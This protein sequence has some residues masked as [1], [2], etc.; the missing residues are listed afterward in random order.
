MTTSVSSAIRTFARI[1]FRGGIALIGGMLADT[2]L[3]P[4]LDDKINDFS[5]QPV[6]PEVQDFIGNEM[7]KNLPR[8]DGEFEIELVQGKDAYESGR[9]LVVGYEHTE[10]YTTVDVHPRVY[11]RAS[12]ELDLHIKENRDLAVDRFFL[13]SEAHSIVAQLN[14]PLSLMGWLYTAFF[15]VLLIPRNRFK[16]P[17]SIFPLLAC[18]AAPL[19]TQLRADGKTFH[20][21]NKSD[22][23]SVRSWSQGKSPESIT[24]LLKIIPRDMCR[25]QP[26]PSLPLRCWYIN[27]LKREEM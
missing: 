26:H 5:R 12:P 17:A 7:L 27:S 8:E 13:A 6:T 25:I 10:Q 16:Y 23:E 24:S 1:Y 11:L 18:Q 2:T 20:T 15:C 14:S 19:I 4:H 21:L 22:Q 3:I 9:K